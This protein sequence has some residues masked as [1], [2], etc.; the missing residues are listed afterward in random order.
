MHRIVKTVLV[1][2]IL[3][4]PTI[5][6]LGQ[7]A[8]RDA[9]GSLVVVMKDGRRQ[10][11]PVAEITK[12]EFKDADIVVFRDGGQKSFR[13]SETQSFEFDTSLGFLRERKADFVEPTECALVS[14]LPEEN[15]AYPAIQK[16]TMRRAPKPPDSQARKL[17][18]GFWAEASA[19]LR[20]YRCNCLNIGMSAFEQV[21][22]GPIIGGHYHFGKPSA[23]IASIRDDENYAIHVSRTSVTE[24]FVKN[25][26]YTHLPRHRGF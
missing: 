7:A 1:G 14:R 26:R 8:S 13:M 20:S 3:V 12:I 10:T 25:P 19:R 4:A 5:G 16:N 21:A 17:T 24:S 6:S 2:I 22:I 11:I 23:H 9:H 15:S 18:F